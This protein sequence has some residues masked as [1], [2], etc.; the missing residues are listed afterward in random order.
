MNIFPLSDLAHQLGISS[1]A[2]TRQALALGLAVGFLGPRWG[3]TQLGR[4]LQ[5]TFAALDSGRYA[6][7]ID[8]MGRVVGFANW[9]LASAHGSVALIAHG[10]D[11]VA[12]LP[13]QATG[14]LWILDF[15]AYGRSLDAI[16]ADLRDRVLRDHD[17][18]TYFRYRGSQRIAKRINRADRTAFFRAAVRPERPAA[19][20]ASASVLDKHRDHMQQ[21]IALGLCLL[22]L[23]RCDP[24]L[25]SPLWHGAV[26]RDLAVLE[27]ARVY[28]D[29]DGRP[30]GLLTWGWLSAHTVARL[31]ATPLHTAHVSEWNEGRLLCLCDALASAP[32]RMQ[33][34][35]DVCAK[36][37]ADQ[38]RILLYT[39]PCD[40]RAASVQ[41]IDRDDRDDCAAAIARWAACMSTGEA[42]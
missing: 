6:F 24:A 12:L 34:M 36:L 42:R 4:R 3:G 17:E 37:F 8:A 11:A 26:L 14:A 33:V 40:E 7:Y 29:A 21:A 13:H 19:L 1:D 41:Q 9:T 35:D 22:A 20:T 38:R 15:F 25:R 16:L 28:C 30:A 5:P 39:P 31:S 27:Q 2:T 32:V 23:R 18:V 10:P